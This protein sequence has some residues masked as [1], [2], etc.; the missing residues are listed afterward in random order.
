M[1]KLNISQ[2]KPQ[3]YKKNSLSIYRSVV[4]TATQLEGRS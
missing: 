3:T 1:K 4:L 2:F